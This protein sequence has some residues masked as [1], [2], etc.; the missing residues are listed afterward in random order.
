MSKLC[1]SIK[2]L[3]VLQISQT[4]DTALGIFLAWCCCP[5]VLQYLAGL[6]QQ[7]NSTWLQSWATPL[8][9]VAAVADGLQYHIHTCVQI[10]HFLIMTRLC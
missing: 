5:D 1:D 9:I 6:P 10:N 4:T 2:K 8:C 7:T 3:L